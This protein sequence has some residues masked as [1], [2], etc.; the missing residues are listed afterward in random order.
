MFPEKNSSVYIQCYKHD[1]S[2]NRTWDQGFVL[3]SDENHYVL[4]TNKTWVIEKDGRKWFTREPAIGYFYTD[5]WFN[6]M[7]MIRKD[8]IYYYCNL[9]SPVLYDGE[10][11]KYIDYDLDFKI[12]SD[13]KIIMLDQDE[14][15]KHS[16]LMNYPK[17]IDIII[18]SEMQKVLMDVENRR[19]PFNR[20]YVEKHFQQYLEQLT[21]Q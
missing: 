12:F 5:R 17:E 2:L 18:K 6:V 10:A 11:V 4:V 21:N 15:E 14:Y 20:Q 3:E 8:G 1:G 9:A 19:K 7:A 16:R 13:N